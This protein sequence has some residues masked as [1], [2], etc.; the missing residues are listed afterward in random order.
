MSKESY[1]FS[2]DYNARSD[3]KLVNVIMKHG[4][5]GIGVYWCVV[6]M[7]YEEGGYL[8]LEYDRIAFELRCESDLVKS[9]VKD[10]GLFENDN[11]KFW[12]KAVLE[13]LQLRIEKS[14]KAKASVA[15]RW[16]KSE[17][18]TNDQENDTNVTESNTNVSK[19]NT[20]KDIKLKC[21]LPVNPV[22][23]KLEFYN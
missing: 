15:S 11:E 6:E 7:A 9:I 23:S 20:R 2:H 17:A 1:Y 4:M 8:P 19:S 22:Q 21:R 3:R 13:R 10:F 5:I 16:K 18:K 14:K 12:S